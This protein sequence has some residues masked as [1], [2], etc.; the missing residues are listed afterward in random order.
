MKSTRRINIS[1]DAHKSVI[2]SGDHNV[3]LFYGGTEAPKMDLNGVDETT[4]NPYMGIDSF[5][6][7]EVDCFFGREVLSRKIYSAIVNLYEES[8]GKEG[9]VRLLTI[10]GPSGCGKSSVVRAGFIAEL[11]TS[12]IPG[13]KQVQ[14]VV[15]S[16]GTRPI[17]RLAKA[18]SRIHRQDASAI[19]YAEKIEARLRSRSN[20]EDAD[21]LRYVAGFLPEIERSPLIIIIDQ[22]EELFDRCKDQHE[23]ELFIDNLLYAASDQD[24]QVSIVLVMR[25]DFLDAVSPF[26]PLSHI[27]AE[28]SIIVPAMSPAEL[29]Q[30]ILKPA[31]NAGRAIDVETVDALIHQTQGRPGALPLLQMALEQ[32]WEG[33]RQ[34]KDP[35]ETLENLG[36]VGGALAAVADGIYHDQSDEDRLFIRKAFLA[37]VQPGQGRQ[38][39]RRQ[40]ALSDICDSDRSKTQRI[41]LLRKFAQPTRRLLT[42]SGETG[43]EVFA[44]VIHETLFSH[45]T[46][47]QQWIEQARPMIQLHH[48]AREAARHWYEKARPDGLLWRS[49]ALEDLNRLSADSMQTLSPAVKAFQAAGIRAQERRRRVRRIGLGISIATAM[50]MTLLSVISFQMKQ[51]ADL[52]NLQAQQQSEKAQRQGRLALARLLANQADQLLSAKPV[53]SEGLE[54]AALLAVESLKQTPTAEGYQA[55]EKAMNRIPP[56]A[57]VYKH[58]KY[59]GSLTLS[60]DGKYLLVAENQGWPQKVSG[61]AK[62][63]KVDDSTGHTIKIDH[64][65]RL[66][67][68]VFSPNN[69]FLVTASWDHTIT[70]TDVNTGSVTHHGP[71]QAPVSALAFSPNSRYLA[72]AC[73]DGRVYVYDVKD[74]HLAITVQHQNLVYDVLFSHDNRFIITAGKDRII[75]MWHRETGQ[76]IKTFTHKSSV[77]RM[78][79]SPNGKHLISKCDDDQELH[80]WDLKYGKEQSRLKHDKAIYDVAISK[81]GHHIIT[82]SED[83]RLRVWQVENAIVEQ[84]LSYDK[85]NLYN[86]KD[87]ASIALSPKADKIVIVSGEPKRAV[88]WD[89]TTGKMV[90]R[91]DHPKVSC[92]AFSPNGN[93]I[94]T[95]GNDYWVRFWDAGTGKEIKK[96]YHERKVFRLAFSADG[97]YVASAFVPN[98]DMDGRY[99]WGE[100]I[101]H[102]LESDSEILRFGG[103][104]A[105]F[106]SLRFSSDNKYIVSA[107]WDH[108]ARIWEAQTGRELH[109][110]KHSGPVVKA[111]FDQEGKSIVTHSKL[112]D[113]RRNE[114]LMCKIWHISTSQAHDCYPRASRTHTDFPQ[115]GGIG[116]CCL[117]NKGRQMWTEGHDATVRLWDT[118]NGQELKRLNVPPNEKVHRLHPKGLSF[119]TI[120]SAKPNIVIIRN[121]P[122]GEKAATLFHGNKIESIRFSSDGDKIAC[123]SEKPDVLNVWDTTNYTAIS[124]I[125]P[126][127]EDKVRSSLRRFTLN[128]DGSLAATTG[129]CPNVRIWD[130]RS[131]KQ[132]TILGEQCSKGNKPYIVNYGYMAHDFTQDGKFFLTYAPG[133]ITVWDTDNWRQIS[134]TKAI[135]GNSVVI[136]TS[137]DGGLFWA[138]DKTG[139]KMFDVDSCSPLF[140]HP[141]SKKEFPWPRFSPD[142]RH[143]AIAQGRKV[144]MRDITSVK[145]QKIYSLAKKTRYFHLLPELELLLSIDTDR[146]AHGLSLSTGKELYTFS[147][148]G[149]TP[150]EM[151]SN[152]STGISDSKNNK[153]EQN[154]GISD[155]RSKG[156]S[157]ISLSYNDDCIFPLC[158][159][160]KVQITEKRN[161]Q[162]TSSEIKVWDAKSGERMGDFMIQDAK[163]TGKFTLNS[164]ETLLATTING[165]EVGLWDLKTCKQLSRFKVE[166]T[167]E[168]F[169]FGPNNRY[170]AISTN[171]DRLHVWDIAEKSMISE[172]PHIDSLDEFLFTKEGDRVITSS[173]TGLVR[174]WEIGG[175]KIQCRKMIHEHGKGVDKILITPDGRSLA[176]KSSYTDIDYATVWDLTT[177]KE[178]YRIYHTEQGYPLTKNS[179]KRLEKKKDDTEPSENYIRDMAM[180]PDGSIIATAGAKGSVKLWDFKNGRKI[181]QLAYDH[182]W[183][184]IVFSPDGKRLAIATSVKEEAAGYHR[185]RDHIAIWTTDGDFKKISE[186][187]GYFSTYHFS[188]DSNMLITAEGEE[189]RPIVNTDDALLFP[190]PV[191]DPQAFWGVRIWDINTGNEIMRTPYKVPVGNAVFTKKGDR[192]VA[193]GWTVKT[194]DIY[195][196]ATGEPFANLQYSDESA[197]REIQ[198]SGSG[199][200]MVTRHAHPSKI[201]VWDTATWMINAVLYDPTVGYG[202]RFSPDECNVVWKNDGKVRIWDWVTDRKMAAINTGGQYSSHFVFSPDGKYLISGDDSPGIN[203]WLWHSQDLVAEGCRRL[204]RNLSREDWRT[205]V[206][207]GS[208]PSTC[209]I[210]PVADRW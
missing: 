51:S 40:L 44:E 59:P 82:T 25:S 18:L 149:H 31:K 90:R 155:E 210:L 174:L 144:Y 64:H 13:Y 27:M 205:Y 85:P 75:R 120:D 142:G 179:I 76:Q 173:D 115:N 153:P 135:S 93:T 184:E 125:V 29:R 17:E 121:L 77:L 70:L 15:L 105:H 151:Q 79:M 152:Y 32:I 186:I 104:P 168:R 128:P 200:F 190:R 16:P 147:H 72:A 207:D 161:E 100:A 26:P 87:F 129:H 169:L 136:D 123:G 61:S 166:G 134:Q 159:E 172:L 158:E 57:K 8:G 111:A 126:P 88:L 131:G 197:V 20:E 177:G 141:I 146:V 63:W 117:I 35:A 175:T 28:Q 73:R 98:P 139:I 171:D 53:K 127:R 183:P 23:Q 46:L 162:N 11:A 206:G 10:L 112:R 138:I 163:S 181:T 194:L 83:R 91:L 62:L 80:V 178:R 102:D 196:T 86:P 49:P 2:V 107:S 132:V 165:N 71:H 157:L 176:T 193:S 14:S 67:D 187:S 89:I 34:D 164:D 56:F 137:P 114:G 22:L 124:R 5:T 109:V 60:P 55:W 116:A 37:M 1:G 130:T 39:S 12:S 92:G 74:M 154:S 36:G 41:A 33:M 38:Y 191:H 204:V 122:N 3:V 198:F 84:T 188:P 185:R 167:I 108:T 99:A 68:I 95:A 19:Q 180:K 101:I 208:E 148:T 192:F 7:R 54:K 65:G 43:G 96:I 24:R 106:A 182:E 50:V 97:N 202:L 133:R 143:F 21:G 203:L 94:A 140:L 81:D 52:N 145:N 6:E 201:M 150:Q 45:W 209:P 9:A 170:L 30:A 156:A 195:Q 66:S 69:R 113:T 103:H 4:S 110:F 189:E 42:L 47:L 119:A 199:K 160:A 48:R 58:K 118:M 78:L